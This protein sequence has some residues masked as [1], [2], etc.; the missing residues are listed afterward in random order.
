MILLILFL[1]AFLAV[2]AVLALVAWK[3]FSVKDAQGQ[4]TTQ[5][6]LLGLGS[7]AALGCLGVLALIAFAVG[8]A[9]ISASHSVHE[10]VE[11]QDGV[12]IGVVR[13]A[14]ER[15]THDERRT[16]HV[17]LEW[18]GDSEP[19]DECGRAIM[20]LCK[21]TDATCTTTHAT[22]DAGEAVTRLDIALAADERMLDE[23]EAALREKEPELSLHQGVQVEFRGTRVDEQER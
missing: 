3:L 5:G 19:T 6:C 20:D 11:S 18:K 4:Q 16:L 10:F 9:A 1:F 15:I 21:A 13:D 14:Q 2:L 8:A 23:I 22:N 12:S 7:V 17:L